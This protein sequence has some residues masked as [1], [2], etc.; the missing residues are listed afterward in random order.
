MSKIS[1]YKKIIMLA[2]VLVA[3]IIIISTSYIT[4][5]NQ[6]HIEPATLFETTEETHPADRYRKPE[7]FYSNFEYF[8]IYRATGTINNDA[9]I[10][11]NGQLVAGSPKFT[12]I[13]KQGANYKVANTMNIQ[14]KLA[15]DWIGFQSNVASYQNYK[16]GEKANLTIANVTQ[17]FPAKGDLWFTTVKHPTLYALIQWTDSTDQKRYYTYLELEFDEY[18]EIPVIPTEPTAAQ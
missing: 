6:T 3:V 4:E 9:Y 2:L 17:T 10:D 12:V 1:K 8:K 18:N 16:V 11:A 15:A 7:E 5:Y 13:S 14:I